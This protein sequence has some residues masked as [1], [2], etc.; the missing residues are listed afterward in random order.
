MMDG[1]ASPRYYPV[2]VSPAAAAPPPEADKQSSGKVVI[3]RIGLGG[4]LQGMR[5]LLDEDDTVK[6]GSV[7]L[8]SSSSVLPYFLRSTAICWL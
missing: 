3:D 6:R 4:F 2:F 7:T 8:G 5:D 1:L